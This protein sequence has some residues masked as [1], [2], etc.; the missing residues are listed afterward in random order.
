M[1][2]WAAVAALAVATGAPLAWGVAARITATF[3]QTLNS[4]R[5]KQWQ[6]VRCDNSASIAGPDS[7]TSG[8]TC[9]SGDWSSAMDC[10]GAERV[11][12]YYSEYGAG[13][14]VVKLW[15][16]LAPV[17]IVGAHRPGFPT[18]ST[19]A[20]PGIEAPGGSPSASD[21]DPLCTE[22]TMGLTLDG[23]TLKKINFASSAFNFL[24]TEVDDCTGNCDG[25]VVVQCDYSQND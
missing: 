4:G 10:R 8:E 25:N 9:E 14:G 15:D 5:V 11:S 20:E 2:R 24:V 1:K 16:C 3:Y 7:P 12:V 6:A 23:T 19:V 17:G 13:S 18:I 22:L 21:P